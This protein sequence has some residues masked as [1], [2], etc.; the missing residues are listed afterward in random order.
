MTIQQLIEDLQQAMQRS[1]PRAEVE[2][3]T[4]YRFPD[5]GTSRPVEAPVTAIIEK[6]VRVII[7]AH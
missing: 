7:E 3:H 6:G 4:V 2:I 5:S 1:G